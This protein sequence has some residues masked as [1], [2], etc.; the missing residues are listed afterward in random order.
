MNKEQEILKKAKE[1]FMKYG[2]R[3]ITMDDLAHHLSFSKKTL[4]Q[5]YKDKADLIRKIII[6]EISEM[7]K[8]MEMLFKNNGNTIDRMIKINSYLIEM[9]KKTPANVKFDLEKYYPQI[10]SESKEIM[11]KKMF[12]AIKKNHQLGVDEGFVRDNFDISIIAYLQVCRSGIIENIVSVFDDYDYEKI[13][14]EIFDYHIRAISTA[15]GLE[16]YENNFKNVK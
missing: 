14:N 1:L 8:M 6:T 9:R 15:K 16:Y 10:A 2:F 3:S 5:Y 13:L 4:Y 7:A 11:E 12:E